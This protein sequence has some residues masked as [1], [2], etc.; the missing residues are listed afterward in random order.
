MHEPGSPVIAGTQIPARAWLHTQPH[1]G[2]SASLVQCPPGEEAPLAADGPRPVQAPL[3][4]P[5]LVDPPLLVTV[6]VPVLV[7]VIPLLVPSNVEDKQQ[8]LKAIVARVNFQRKEPVEK[9]DTDIPPCRRHGPSCDV[10]SPAEASASPVHWHQPPSNASTHCGGMPAS[11]CRQIAP[12]S[13]VLQ[14]A[15]FAQPS[16]DVLRQ[17]SHWRLLMPPP[18][19]NPQPQPP[20]DES[21]P[22]QY[23]AAAGGWQVNVS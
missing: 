10:Q 3:V 14:S 2:Q 11:T 21:V 17:V 5:A 1:P 9:S 7:E 19:T 12:V 15:S 23:T 20:T 18:Q 16:T 13:Q 6:V 8:P 4:V 22:V